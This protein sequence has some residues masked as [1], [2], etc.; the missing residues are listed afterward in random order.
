MKRLILLGAILG[1]AVIATA[2][3][4]HGPHRL[5]VL[6]TQL[7]D[8]DTS[9]VAAEELA[10]MGESVIPAV[11]ATPTTRTVGHCRAT[12]L[13]QPQSVS[14]IGAVKCRSIMTQAN[15]LQD[16]P[17]LKFKGKPE[18]DDPLV[19]VGV[20]GRQGLGPVQARLRR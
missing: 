8:P 9:A 16:S 14:A 18:F 1:L 11:T 7:G 13:E 5:Q 12:Q 17:V 4:P 10:S 6:L 15:R 19:V 20:S 2:Q 3:A